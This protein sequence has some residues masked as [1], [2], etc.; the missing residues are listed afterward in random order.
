MVGGVLRMDEPLAQLSCSLLHIHFHTALRDA[1]RRHSLE[2][3][4]DSV[5]D[6]ELA[7]LGNCEI[8]LTDIAS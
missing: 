4:V 1:T 5:V 7:E 3:L 6:E 2:V 8:D